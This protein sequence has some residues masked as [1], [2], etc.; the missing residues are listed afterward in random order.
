MRE[1]FQRSPPCDRSGA[2]GAAQQTGLGAAIELV[3]PKVL[4]VCA[5]PN[6]LPFSNEQGEGFENKLAELIAGKLGKSVSYTYFPMV[7]GFVRNTL[8]AHKCDVII[9]F[10]QGDELVQNTNRLLPH[11]L[12]PDL[13]AEPRAGRP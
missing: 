13:Q 9:G 10:P 5:D 4:R 3:D 11:R 6:N 8:G 12:C 1:R 7:T 2:S